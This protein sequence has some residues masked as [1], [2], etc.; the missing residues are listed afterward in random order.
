MGACRFLHWL[1][2]DD[3]TGKYSFTKKALT[4]T[5]TLLT[6]L[7]QLIAFSA[8]AIVCHILPTVTPVFPDDHILTNAT[9][10]PFG[11]FLIILN[12]SLLSISA[13]ARKKCTAGGKFV[14]LLRAA[15]NSLALNFMSVALTRRSSS[16]NF[17][18]PPVR[19]WYSLRNILLR[20]V[21]YSSLFIW[22]RYTQWLNACNANNKHKTSVAAM[23]GCCCSVTSRDQLLSVSILVSKPWRNDM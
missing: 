17:M 6:L 23:F 21:K 12:T 20:N 1:P 22:N 10:V 16:D 7:T 18:V 11:I 8:P 14:T 5:I 15:S 2:L 13:F 3:G 4:P 19:I 9:N